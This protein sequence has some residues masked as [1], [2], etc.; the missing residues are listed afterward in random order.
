MVDLYNDLCERYKQEIQDYSDLPDNWDGYGTKGI[1]KG[2]ITEVIL[3]MAKMITEFEK[4]GLEF[5]YP[6]IVID[7]GYLGLEWTT[8]KFKM[9]IDIDPCS[10]EIPVFAWTSQENRYYKKWK[11]NTVD[12]EFLEWMREVL[13]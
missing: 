6:D 11:R 8:D 1:K 4:A 13:K 9:D 2:S 10:E 7:N 3:F 5:I 12:P